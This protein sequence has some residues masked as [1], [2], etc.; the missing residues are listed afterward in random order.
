MRPHRLL[1][2]A[3]LVS[4]A[5]PAPAPASHAG[6]LAAQ[7]HF[8]AEGPSSNEQDLT[9]DS[10]GHGLDAIT[11]NLSLKIGD[12]GRFGRHLSDT[13]SQILSPDPSA[14]LRPQR[15]TLL[16]WVRHMGP[17]GA[18]KYIAHQ[19]DDGFLCSSP[20]YALYTGAPASGLQFFISRPSGFGVFS[21]V[22]GNAIWDGQWHMVAGTWDGETVRLYVDGVQVGS[23]TP[24]PGATIGYGVPGNRFGI[25]GYTVP[26]AGV[27]GFP[28]GIDELRVYNR[29][30]TGTEL[31]R[32][33]AATAPDPPV[34]VADSDVPP[35]SPPVQPPVVPPTTPVQ[36]VQ[37]RFASAVN[38]TLKGTIRLNGAL[39]NPPPG[40]SITKFSWDF[41]ADGK[42][43]ADCGA[44]APVAT[45][46]FTKTG[47][48]PVVLKTLDSLGR[49]ASVT[50]PVTVK[51]DQINRVGGS[52]FMCADP[53]VNQASSKDC[54]KTFSFGIVEV[55]G[56]G[57]SSQ[58]F[59]LEARDRDLFVKATRSQIDK[60]PASFIVYH[61]KISGPVALNGIPIPVPS[62]R[63][64]EYD[65]GRK[66]I[67]IGRL[68]IDLGLP[69]RSTPLR[70]A[71]VPLE[72]EIK[73]VKGVF[74][75]PPLKTSGIKLGVFGGLKL[76]GGIEVELRHRSANVKISLKLPDVF[77]VGFRR[78]AEGSV[79][80][81][82]SNTTGFGFEGLR[83]SQIPQ[84]FLGPLYVTDLFF[85]YQR[86]G[87]IW[88]G[89]ANFQL[90]AVSPV[91]IKAAPPPPDYGFGLKG[92]SFEYAGG[93]VAFPNP[94][95]PQLFPGIGLV[96]IGGSIGIDPVRF[97]GRMAIDVGG[98][99]VIDGTVFVGLASED[100][101][102]K[103]P[104]EFAPTGLGFLA[105]RTL[106]SVSIAIGGE[107]K[108]KV[109]VLGEIPLV[110]AHVFY[111]YPDYA[112][113]GGFFKYN[114]AD[115]FS[116]EGK[117]GGF[118]SVGTRTFNLEGEVKG[119]ADI[120]V[121]TFCLNVGA[122]VSSKGIGFCTI[123]PIPI[124]IVGGTVPVPAGIGYTWGGSVDVQVFSCDI[125]PYRE[126]RPAA[127]GAQ[128]GQGFSLDAGL[129]SAMVRIRGRGGV[130]SVTVTGPK[131][132]KFLA[133]GVEKGAV[134]SSVV[135]IPQTPDNTLLIGLKKPSAGRW[136]VTAREGS[137]PVTSVAAADGLDA[138]RVSVSVEGAGAQR[139]LSYKVAV[140]DGQRVSFAEK[141]ARTWHVIGAA[142]GAS[143]RLAFTPALGRSGTRTIV[144]LVERDGVLVKT[145]NVTRF[146]VGRAPRP[147]APAVLRVR[148]ERGGL[149]ISWRRVPGAARYAV[150]VRVS[151][152]PDVF[153]VTRAPQLFVAGVDRAVRG[154]V[155][156][157]GL[158]ADS[159]TGARTSRPI[160]R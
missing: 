112:E 60:P 120:E 62:D 31:A 87:E 23:G 52:L 8:D 129:P 55:N 7:W 95:R 53:N 131:G 108:I 12:G 85:E 155:I 74:K 40:V 13:N 138:P 22:P 148:R 143:G 76:G 2:A 46:K 107:A 69:G 5:F 154:T 89:G 33:A 21:P 149:A 28:G 96:E 97:T 10:S 11:G 102:Y 160:G 24:G 75:L 80:L 32:L 39:T 15:L 132:E 68:P 29:A 137:V 41:N 158:R 150:S 92:G 57:R 3:L 128:A 35:P 19:G 9:L 73:P 157:A 121:T 88:R 56:R 116:V 64:T 86:T 100:A 94:P 16:A 118:A 106:D 27:S 90:A 136:T 114:L 71:D 37:P 44:D 109:P 152:R 20:S 101:R 82:T 66:T 127:R 144:A 103:F 105:G 78:E 77:N 45:T 104:A 141:G 134:S 156:V 14:E 84:V 47:T 125:G 43:D 159:V 153:R 42:T 18:V 123:V 30:L 61:A 1:F 147:A 126:V 65:S 50:Q 151:R 139:V 124:P 59:E 36:D 81:R 51:A 122:V 110:N 26:C 113:F 98:L 63:I 146:A 38:T 58:C 25:D 119:C 142:R 93:G 115:R 135:V 54:I 70:I 17:P 117:V 83:I 99:F 48:Y 34:L 6:P 111:A 145:L 133:G 130:P 72:Y 4:W 91:Q 79:T 49:T 67:S 140:A